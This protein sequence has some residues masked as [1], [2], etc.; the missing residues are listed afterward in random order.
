MPRKPAQ[1]TVAA[2]PGRKV[3]EPKFSDSESDDEF[4]RRDVIGLDAGTD[5]PCIFAV[6]PLPSTRCGIKR[7]L[8]HFLNVLCRALLYFR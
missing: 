7:G 2:K 1:K 6:V 4:A 5:F 8:A 3:P